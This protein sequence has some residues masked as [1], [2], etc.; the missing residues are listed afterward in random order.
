[1][2]RPG[3]EPRSPGPLANTLTARP[4]SGS[5]L[6]TVKSY[7]KEVKSVSKVKNMHVLFYAQAESK[8][9]TKIEKDLLD[10]G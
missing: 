6:R 2:T 10:E 3:I 8:R 5:V 4:M 7:N 1:M 9:N